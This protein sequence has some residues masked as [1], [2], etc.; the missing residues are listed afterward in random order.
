MDNN[1]V[2]QSINSTAKNKLFVQLQNEFH[3]DTD[4]LQSVFQKYYIGTDANLDPV[5]WQMNTQFY[6]F[7]G[8][9]ED[10]LIWNEKDRPTAI[11]GGHLLNPFSTQTV[12]IVPTP[13]EAV[14]FDM[15]FPDKIWVAA[16]TTNR[17]AQDLPAACKIAILGN[18]NWAIHTYNYLQSINKT[19]TIVQKQI[20]IQQCKQAGPP[21]HCI[22]KPNFEIYSKAKYRKR[23]DLKQLYK[24]ANQNEHIQ[25]LLKGLD[26]KI[27]NIEII[28]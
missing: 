26:C 27:E 4:T 7:N 11:F 12:V 28:K 2:I 5:Y 14:I 17:L 25:A 18:K 1:L 16:A 22:T 19:C 15:Y 24:S 20:T 10:K 13:K 8:T 9:V 23:V 21:E 3:I 6:L